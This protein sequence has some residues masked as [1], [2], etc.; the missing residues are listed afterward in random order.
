MHMVLLMCRKKLSW[1]HRFNALPCVMPRHV[2]RIQSVQKQLKICKTQ[3]NRWSGQCPCRDALAFFFHHKKLIESLRKLCEE[4]DCM[5]SENGVVWAQNPINVVSFPLPSFRLY[6]FFCNIFSEKN[7]FRFLTF[8]LHFLK[9]NSSHVLLFSV[10]NVVQL[11]L[12]LS[13]RDL[14]FFL[15][16]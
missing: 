16:F 14:P 9:K 11:T 4:P 5:F 3:Y 15:I 7:P 12:S 2:L 13:W 6:F 10:E 8:S 1:C